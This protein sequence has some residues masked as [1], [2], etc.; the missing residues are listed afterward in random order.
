MLSNPNTSE[1]NLLDAA[2][3]LVRDRITPES[4][5]YPLLEGAP[6]RNGNVEVPA[7]T[8]SPQRAGRNLTSTETLARR[9][10]WGQPQVGDMP[11]QPPTV[12]GRIG[13]VLVSL[14]RRM[15]FWYTDQIRS[16]HAGVSEAAAE[17]VRFAHE[18][19]AEQRRQGELLAQGIERITA[20]E[21]RQDELAREHM[22]ALT[23]RFDELNARLASSDSQTAA[24]RARF[25]ELHK[26]QRAL[27]QSVSVHAEWQE[28]ESRRQQRLAA[29]LA[30]IDE[31]LADARQSYASVAD[32]SG[33]VARIGQTLA[34]S[35]QAY[36]ALAENVARTEHEIAAA[37]QARIHFEAADH[38]RRDALADHLSQI[39]RAQAALADEARR[40]QEAAVE[41]L[42]QIE[43]SAATARQ[44]LTSSLGREFT[45][46][47]QLLHEAKTQLL[48]QE[49]RLK[50]L[51]REA[52]TESA[53]AAN[54]TLAEEV[55][56]FPDTLFVDH[57]RSFRG[58]RTEIKH[59]LDVYLPH[60]RQ[61]FAAAG[62]APALDLGC[63][64]GEWLE[65]LTAA[66]IPVKGIDSNR[67]LVHACLQLELDAI[68]G[69]IPRSL[70]SL[71]DESRS[72]V[73]AFHVLEHLSFEDLLEVIDQTV[74]LLKPGG[75]AI[76][77]TPNP[78]N[79]LV[80]TNNFYLDPTHHHPLPSEFL[81]FVAEARGLCDPEV[82]PL[83]P[84]PDCFHLAGDDC[85]AVEFINQHFFGP[86]DYGI[87]ARK[88]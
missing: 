14:V 31:A 32:L 66:G 44:E 16:F 41:R 28:E 68:E 86:Q 38:R 42:D 19:D 36:A 70:H 7:G 45:G 25:E 22:H 51:L 87:V 2:A 53:P 3:R 71:P 34:A 27:A 18:I 49:L 61:A 23:R 47:R 54:S 1:L 64:R 11:P 56:R 88:G 13:A 39:E 4:R 58:S 12:R 84:Y 20:F 72:I 26:E 5:F 59:R 76:F 40:S 37:Q 15:L 62:G 24:D 57:A 79:L 50:M 21:R 30:Q 6:A 65:I 33:H 82:I 48:Q 69:A 77:E 17:Q 29:R 73:T 67:E 52:R 8:L 55:R 9:V 74:R 43:A 63:G 60:A 35:H 80:S 46:L 10:E 81:A 85:A 83:S 78:K 75:I